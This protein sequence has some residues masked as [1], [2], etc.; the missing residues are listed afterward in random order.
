MVIVFALAAQTQNVSFLRS[1]FTGQMDFIFVQ[2]S[3]TSIGLP[4]NNHFHFQGNTVGV[5]HTVE[6]M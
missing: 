2:Y 5:N 6:S 3:A 4:N 1:G